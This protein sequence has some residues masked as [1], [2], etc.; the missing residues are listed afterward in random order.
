MCVFVKGVAVTGWLLLGGCYWVRIGT[1][2]Q[3][4]CIVGVDFRIMPLAQAYVALP[5]YR[6]TLLDISRDHPTA[7][8][9]SR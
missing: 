8:C 7:Y 9:R 4:Y 2:G 5:T 1:Q 3:V 6:Y